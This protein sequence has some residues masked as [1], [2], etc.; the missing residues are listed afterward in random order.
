MALLSLANLSR[1]ALAETRALKTEEV[2]ALVGESGERTEDILPEDPPPLLAL[3]DGDADAGGHAREIV[4]PVALPENPSAVVFPVLA[5]AEFILTIIPTAA[6]ISGPL[7]SVRRTPAVVCTCSCG[8]SRV[9]STQR[10][11]FSRGLP[12]RVASP[13]GAKPRIT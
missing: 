13:I 5:T 3:T 2:K 12:L 9:G 4:A 1:F 10:P 11:F 6:V 7:R 8:T